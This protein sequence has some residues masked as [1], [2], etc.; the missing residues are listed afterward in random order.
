MKSAICAIA[1]NEEDYLLEWITYHLNLGFD[2]IFL[3]DNNDPGD[4]STFRLCTGQPWE[5]QITIIDYRGRIAAQLTAYNECYTAIRKDFDWVAFIDVD[6]FITFGTECPYRNINQYL[7][8][9]KEFNVI[10]INW[11]YYGDN[12]KVHQEKEDVI[13]R[14]PLPIPDC[15]E[16][17]HIKSIIKTSADIKFVRNPHCPDGQVQICD[18]CQYPISQSEPF[19]Q[20]SFKN[21]YIRHYGTKTIEEFIKNKMLR[22]AADQNNNPYKIDLF[23]RI[24]KHTKEKREIERRFFHIHNQRE[25]R[26]LVSVIIPNYNHKRFLKQRIDSVL[27]QTFTDFELILLD[28]CSTDNSQQLLLS[29]KNN[30]HVSY[31]VLNTKNGGSPFSQWEKGIRL[32]KG[33]YIWIA[34]SDDSATSDFL[35]ITVKQLEAHPQAR[36]CFTG[37]YIINGDNDPVQTNEFDQWELDGKAYIFQSTDYLKTHML[38]VNSVYNASMVLFRKE[39]CLTDICNRYRNMRYCGD[40]LFWIEQIRKGE[41]I[42][43]HQKANFFRKHDSNTTSQGIEEGKALGEIAFLKKRLYETTIKNWKEVLEDKY[44]Y[45]RIVRSYPVSTARRKKQL[46]RIIA[47]EGNIT[48][49]HYLLWKLYKLCKKHGLL[50]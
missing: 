20:P 28:D 31:V 47:Q 48:F 30:P 10:F 23:Y 4:D 49:R 46:F 33:K 21:L 13:T 34:E 3:C 7:G 24:N 9:I 17:K 15:D 40:W 6:E 36:L 18:D 5:K 19:K 8:N 43:V 35:S 44:F 12:E 42:E 29:Y 45:Y 27:A 41:V 14:F 22:G 2:H 1:R 38:H 16:N 39:G 32:A 11:M 37:S 26:P 25:N 50:K